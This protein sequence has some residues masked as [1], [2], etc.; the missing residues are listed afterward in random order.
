ML[1]GLIRWAKTVRRFGRKEIYSLQKQPSRGFPGFHHHPRTRK[2]EAYFR[3]IDRDA[4]T[5]P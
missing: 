2:D 3:Y 1:N 5:F 4:K